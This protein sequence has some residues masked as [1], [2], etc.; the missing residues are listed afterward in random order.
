MTHDVACRAC[1][2]SYDAAAAPTH[3][4][5]CGVVVA[6]VP[7]A[8]PFARLG[9]SVPRFGVDEGT[10]ERAW[11]ARS[12]QVHPDRFAR[13]T[14]GE[15]RA[16]ALQTAALNDAWRAI[17]APF[18][19]AVWLT[20]SVGVNEPA[21]PTAALVELM[22]AREEAAVD[23]TNRDAVVAR[24][25]ARFAEVM[26]RA[27]AALA[28]VDDADGWTTPTTA[29]LTEVRRAAASLAE[30]R[31]LARLVADLGGPRLIPTMAER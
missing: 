1:G 31:T 28:I 23:A 14:D 16:A 19:R 15:R 26:S 3:C 11:L 17:R 10:L 13:R 4:P 18:D 24:S 20:R 12:R 29:T 25:V 5:S 2:A 6:P 21:L 9:L 30:A 8:T 22:E 7:H 27:T